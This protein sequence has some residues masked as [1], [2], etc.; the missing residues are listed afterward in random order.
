MN[1]FLF[2]TSSL[3]SSYEFNRHF[4]NLV[5]T[6]AS[7]ARLEE[8]K[9]RIAELDK[10]LA[11]EKNFS[12]KHEQKADELRSKSS[13][14]MHSSF[15]LILFSVIFLYYFSSSSLYETSNGCR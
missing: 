6:R 13:R 7:R 8:A 10:E 3:L 2:Y 14:L 15:A 1:Y 9:V 12:M 5:E 4:A 11:E